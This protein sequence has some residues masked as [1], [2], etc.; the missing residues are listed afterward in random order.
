M[1][2]AVKKAGTERTRREFLATTT[3]LAGAAIVGLS[4]PAKAGKK[5][6]KRG[7]T[8]RFGTRDDSVG[9]DTH[10]NI[11]YFTS[12]PLAGITAGLVDFDDKMEPKPGI[13]E[14]WEPSSDLKTWTFKLRRGAEYHNGQ[15]VDAES[16]K[17]NIERIK[18]PKIGH[19]FTRSVLS[20][21]ERVTVDDKTTVQFHLKEPHAALDVNLVYYPVNLMAP[22]AVDKADTHPV[23][24]GPFKFKSWRRLD[25]TELERFENFYE[26]DAEGNSLPYLDSLIGRPKKED[27]VRLTALRTGEVDLIDNM[28]YADVPAFKK[29][30]GKAYETWP[31]PQVGTAMMFFNLKNGL[32]SEK[33]NPDALLLRQAISHAID[34]E[35][36]HQAVFNELSTVATGF[37]SPASP[38]HSDGIESWPKFDLDKA[39]ALRKKAKGGDQKFTIIANDTFAYMQQSGELVHAMLKDAG[40]NVMLEILPTPVMNEKIAKGDFNIDSTANSYRLDPDGWFAR[41]VLSSAPENRRRIGYKNEKADQLIH[42]ASKVRDRAKRKQMYADVESLVN[43]DLPMLY[44]HYVPTLS[45]GNRA[46]VKGYAPSFSGPWSYAGGGMRR[47]WIEG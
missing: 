29:E 15:T 8:L 16:V 25:L 20:D 32:L 44:T 6:P 22:G 47:T 41:N 9:L 10:R 42:A 35:G 4:Q 36:I 2:D 5:H 27:R 21:V 46:R 12:H 3:A 38:W 33:D 14:S 43:R 39:K 13:A 1:S 37:Y 40:F 24:C 30:H 7:G 31:V 34:H 11:I 17:W 19:A 23:N 28:P 18:D 26:T 45:A